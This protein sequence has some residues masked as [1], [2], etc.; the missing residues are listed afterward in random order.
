MAMKKAIFFILMLLTPLSFYHGEPLELDGEQ[1]ARQ[2]VGLQN[3]NST[4]ALSINPDYDFPLIKINIIQ[5]SR[6]RLSS[7]PD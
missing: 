1:N 4:A 5:S 3:N 6:L 2:I 7:H